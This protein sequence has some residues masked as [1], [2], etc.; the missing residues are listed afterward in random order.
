MI[1]ASSRAAGSSGGLAGRSK[2][3]DRRRGRG[4]GDGCDSRLRDEVRISCSS[5]ESPRS[6]LS[7]SSIRVRT[8]V[9]AA[10]TSSCRGRCRGRA[11]AAPRRGRSRVPRRDA[12]ACRCAGGR[13]P[14][15]S[16]AM[17]LWDVEQSRASSTWERPRASRRS[18]TWAAIEAKS[19][20]SSAWARRR[21]S[22]SN[23]SAGVRF[24]RAFADPSSD[25]ILAIYHV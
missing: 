24:A 21:R 18:V 14:F 4:L 5:T 12:A 16:R 9:G 10:I 8:S 20:P 6:S 25:I 17:A 23:G 7:I 11:G 15:S 2:A 22:R 13:P 19:Q 1:A 3:G